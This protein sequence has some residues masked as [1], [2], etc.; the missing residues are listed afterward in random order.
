M[1]LLALKLLVLSQ[2]KPVASRRIA[3]R[4]FKVERKM[5]IWG[6]TK[7][8]G[9]FHIL[10]TYPIAALSGELGPKRREGDLQAPEGFYYINRFNPHSQFHLSLGLNYPNSS[11]R[12]LS[13]PKHPG[14]D[15]FVHGNQVSA[16]C[17]AMTDPVIDVIYRL[18][19]HA[20][21]AGQR[22]IPVTIFPCRMTAEN[23]AL[24]QK[25]YSQRPDLIK[26]WSTLLPA[27]TSFEKNHI[28][29]R[30]HV[31]KDGRYIWPELGRLE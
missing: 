30:P 17:F 19:S 3:I 26:F 7:D 9:P 11:D 16:G 8:K 12:K 10:A 23:W 14:F 18:A 6:A 13:D 27:Y 22:A 1:V 25:Q 21:D 31:S 24:L 28:W 4:A 20:R 5:E 29:P 2:K 15:I